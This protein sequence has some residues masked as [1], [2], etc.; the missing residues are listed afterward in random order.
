MAKAAEAALDVEGDLQ[1]PDPVESHY[2]TEEEK[3][4]DNEEV[5]NQEKN[6]KKITNVR[7]GDC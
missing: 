7:G 4:I 3:S 2:A 1:I 6:T 5:D